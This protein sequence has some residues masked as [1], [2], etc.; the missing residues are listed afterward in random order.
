MFSH[1]HILLDPNS[2]PSTEDA[3]WLAILVGLN[4]VL[5]IAA[6]LIMIVQ[7]FRQ[8]S[9]GMPMVGSASLTAISLICV[10]GPFSGQK[11]LFY[12]AGK[13][14]MLV[15]VWALGAL[16][17]GLV[18]VQY[19]I[20]GRRHP[21]RAPELGRHFFTIAAFVFALMLATEVSFLVFY[22]DYYVNEICPLAVLVMGLAYFGTM[23]SRPK[24]RG[25]SVTAAWLLTASSFMLYLGTVLGSMDAAYPGHEQTGYGF[26]YW[27]YALTLVALVVYSVL[28]TRRRHELREDWDVKR[29]LDRMGVR[30][31]VDPGIRTG[32]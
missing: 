27:V 10:V 7:G 18:F 8:K 30:S 19:L 12:D 22:Q 20:Y 2:T 26:I 1:L 25:L 6:L 3:R 21:H 28:L 31:E 4:Y 24:L 13:S 16:L 15:A 9:Y 5:A 32:W 14:P 11:H 17:Y 23:F 29:T